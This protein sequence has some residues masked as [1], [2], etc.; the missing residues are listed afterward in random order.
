[1]PRKKKEEAVVQERKFAAPQINSFD[2]II[3]PIVTEKSMQLQKEQNKVTMKVAKNANKAQVKL[4]VE[5]IF[6]IRVV[7]VKIINVAAKAKR[8]GRY[9]GTV[10]A[11]KKAIVTLADGQNIDIT[12]GI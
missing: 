9:E 5:Q 8:V 12:T 4:A 7:D 3:A 6:D 10:P 11:Y 2:V 1:M